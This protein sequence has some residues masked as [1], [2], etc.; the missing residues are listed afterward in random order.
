MSTTI[1]PAY[2]FVGQPPPAPTTWL[3]VV[4][5]CYNEAD[6]IDETYRRVKSVC[7]GHEFIVR[8]R[9][10][11]DKVG[12]SSITDGGAAFR[13]AEFNIAIHCGQVG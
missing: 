9:V 5:P 2:S 11:G 10:V 7:D 4:L 6:V 13:V 8:R 3:S 1:L 12:P